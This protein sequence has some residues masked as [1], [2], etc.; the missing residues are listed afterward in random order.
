VLDNEKSEKVSIQEKPGHNSRSAPARRRAD[1]DEDDAPRARHRDD[2]DDDGSV[3]RRRRDEDDDR[4]SRRKKRKQKA[5]NK[6]LVFG[7]VGAGAFVLILL[8][9]GLGVTAFLWPGFMVS[10]NKVEPVAAKNDVILEVRGKEQPNAPVN[11]KGYLIPEADLLMGINAKGLR[12][13]NQFDAFLNGMRQARPNG[14]PRGFEEIAR[15]CDRVAVS[16]NISES[17]AQKDMPPPPPPKP[18]GPPKGPPGGP[19]GGRRDPGPP[20]MPFFTGPKIVIALL[21]SNADSAARAKNVLRGVPGMGVEEKLTGRYP[22]YRYREGNETTLFAFA[23]DRV[24]VLAPITEQE[25][26]AVIERAAG[27]HLSSPGLAKMVALV[28][29]AHVWAAYTPN[30]AAR[31]VLGS[32][33]LMGDFKGMPQAVHNAVQTLGK[34]KGIGLAVDTPAGGGVKVQMHMDCDDV[35]SAR[36]LKDGADALTQTL[37]KDP[38]APRSLIQDLGSSTFTS[39]GTLA[40]GTVTFSEATAKDV[41]G[42]FGPNP[43]AKDAP[44]GKG[45]GR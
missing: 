40:S 14:L 5:G 32:I 7:L 16:M 1:D 27:T 25:L 3:R 26:S 24:L 10:K 45:K 13:A 15:D 2:D 8:C 11:M 33:V 20:E 21:L 29:Q 12:D 18:F 4:P 44:P 9:G 28:E 31:N 37:T 19:P 39:Q 23:S 6:V 38:K 43:P 42:R 41:S 30:A 17:L 36:R 22:M 35:E 34:V